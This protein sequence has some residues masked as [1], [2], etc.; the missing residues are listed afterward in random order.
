LLE[1]IGDR[2]IHIPDRQSARDN[3]LYLH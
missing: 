2:L 1:V 3:R